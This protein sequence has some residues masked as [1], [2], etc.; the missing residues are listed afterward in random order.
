[1]GGG[2]HWALHHHPDCDNIEMLKLP[3]PTGNAASGAWRHE[4][5]GFEF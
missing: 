4:F 1:M 5:R 3:M 2:G